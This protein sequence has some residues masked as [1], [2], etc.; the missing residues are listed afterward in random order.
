MTYGKPDETIRA[1]R[2][3]FRCDLGDVR[4]HLQS[5]CSQK[6]VELARFPLGHELDTAVG[7]VTNIARDREAAGHALASEAET[8]PLNP[9]REMDSATNP[10]HATPPC[11]R[12]KPTDPDTDC[13]ARALVQ[14]RALSIQQPAPAES[15]H[16]PQAKVDGVTTIILAG[17]D[18]VRQVVSRAALDRSDGVDDNEATASLSNKWP[19]PLVAPERGPELSF[20]CNPAFRLAGSSRANAGM[21]VGCGRH[22][23]AIKG[24]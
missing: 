15:K 9:A 3:G 17:D 2:S 16:G 24:R 1:R 19:A 7:N 23:G 4:T 18:G 14:N 13:R 21:P 11:G 8:H 5:D 10:R 20:E 12:R 6:L 22:W